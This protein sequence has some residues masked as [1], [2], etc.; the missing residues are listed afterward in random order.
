[1][2]KRDRETVRERQR[3]TDRRGREAE[4]RLKRMIGRERQRE[5]RNPN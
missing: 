2:K 5:D 3:E 1:V 4:T